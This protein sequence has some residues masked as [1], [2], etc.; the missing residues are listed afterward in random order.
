[1]IKLSVIIA[2]YNVSEYIVD[3]LDSVIKQVDCTVEVIIVNDGSTDH[4]E[5][6]ITNYISNIIDKNIILINK[7]NG[8]L[9]DARNVG[10]KKSHGDYITFLDGDDI[11][12]DDYFKVISKKLYI[13]DIIEFDAIRFNDVKDLD[14]ND[15]YI[16][17]VS[18]NGTNN[19]CFDVLLNIFRRNQWF[20]WSRV[21]KSSLFK[22]IYFPEHRRFE[23]IATIPILYLNAEVLMSIKEPLVGYRYNP[24]SI[25]SNPKISDI[26]DIMYALNR[27]NESISNSLYKRNL[28]SIATISSAP[29]LKYIYISS[30]DKNNCTECFK[31]SL[32]L[33]KRRIVKSILC[34]Y[35]KKALLVVFFPQVFILFS[36]IKKYYIEKI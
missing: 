13:S 2:A 8:G 19:C 14:Y 32:K 3:C 5:D 33:I 22:N 15:N 26:T 17:L 23:D 25:T 35:N 7:S 36:K 34:K 1:M 29:V 21:Y 6:I 12:L 4:T 10:L 30:N 28:W 9:S 16:K 31:D 11:W 18:N 24:N 27:V 20:A